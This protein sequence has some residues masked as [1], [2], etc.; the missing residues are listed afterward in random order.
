MASRSVV[1]IVLLLGASAAAAPKVLKPSGKVT[2]AEGNTLAEAFAFDES[3]SKL[4]T[5]QYTPRG[6]VL[7]SVGAPGGKSQIT[8]ISSFT[9]TPEKLVGVGGHWFV[10]SNEGQRRAAIIDPAGHLKRTTQH[11]DDCELSF[12]SQGLRRGVGTAGARRQSPVLDSGVQARRRHAHASG[13]GGGGQ[14]NH[15]GRRR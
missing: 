5:I 4:A 12:S 13:R 7:L 8:E 1:S 15:R 10:V 2:A 3:G 9:S 14:R 11:F 6:Q